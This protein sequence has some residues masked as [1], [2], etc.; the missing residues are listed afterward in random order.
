M[1]SKFRKL[2]PYLFLFGTS[3]NEVR[4]DPTVLNKS[5]YWLGNDMPIPYCF[6]S[7]KTSKEVPLS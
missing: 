3:G 4:A 5:E 1:K 2:I 6:M 7:I